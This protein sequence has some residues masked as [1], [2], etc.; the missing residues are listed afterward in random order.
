MANLTVTKTQI[1]SGVAYAEDL[2][3]RKTAAEIE[4]GVDKA[5]RSTQGVASLADLRDIEPVYNA[6]TFVFGGLLYRYDPTD[7]TSTDD[8]SR[9]IVTSGGARYKLITN[10]ANVETFGAEGDS[11]TDDTPA[12]VSCINTY[13]L[14][15]ELSSDKSYLFNDY[16]VDGRTYSGFVNTGVVDLTRTDTWDKLAR[17]YI[18]SNGNI[19]ILDKRVNESLINKI[20]SWD[21]AQ[22]IKAIFS[23]SATV[24]LV[25]TSITEGEDAQAEPIN[26]WANRLKY[27]LQEAFPTVTWNWNNLGLNS[28]RLSDY[29]DSNYLALASEPA[30]KRDGF[31]RPTPGVDSTATVDTWPDG[32][33]VG[34]SWLWH[35]EQTEPD[36]F[37]L[38]MGMNDINDDD[39]YA[40]DVRTALSHARSLAK[41]PSVAFVTEMSSHQTEDNNPE[42][43]KAY[44]R[45]TRYIGRNNGVAVIDVSRWWQ[46]LRTGADETEYVAMREDDITEWEEFGG[47][48]TT[49]ASSI[50]TVSTSASGLLRRGNFCGGSFEFTFEPNASNSSAFVSAQINGDGGYADDSIIVRRA[51]TRF[52]IFDKA[53]NIIQQFT[54]L[55][56]VAAGVDEAITIRI[57]YNKIEVWKENL[58][59][60]IYEME[61]VGYLGGVS[62]SCTNANLTS[63]IC[64]VCH[65][66]KLGIPMLSDDILSGRYSSADWSAGNYSDGGNNINHPSRLGLS[67]A[68]QNSINGFVESII[69]DSQN[70]TVFSE[71][72]DTDISV[73]GTTITDTGDSVTIVMPRGGFITVNAILPYINPNTNT[74]VGLAY[75]YEDSSLLQTRILKINA[76]GSSNTDVE[77]VNFQWSGYKSAGTY[78]YKTR[79]KSLA[80]ETISSNSS[81]N[82]SHLRTLI[83]T[84]K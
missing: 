22:L 71:F 38:A 4:A 58:P 34:E 64:D 10:S 67:I 53:G 16:L 59:V 25:G 80:A 73:T 14:R 40:D 1:N 5:G 49:T 41:V 43:V 76:V 21:S 9:V 48:I 19:W 46:Y 68:Y 69:N 81:T 20:C 33:T 47:A 7:T 65:P 13:N 6:Q 3:S 83:A 51:S 31:W 61:N 26:I 66:K 18:D 56:A 74:S 79:W 42:Q 75:L 84:V 28:R 63:I 29:V 44:S 60:G 72:G 35:V 15:A 11:T 82:T 70:G 39:A 54:G 27:E 62:I 2:K 24:T 52:D 77:Y 8:G 17:E 45:V 30:N 12:I 37:I 23:G 36:L 55:T 50:S 57:I 32:V 78:T